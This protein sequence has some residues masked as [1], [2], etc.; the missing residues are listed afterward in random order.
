MSV[1][2]RK[3]P[4]SCQRQTQPCAGL[5]PAPASV[6]AADAWSR[7]ASV[8]SFRPPVGFWVPGVCRG[9]SRLNLSPFSSPAESSPWSLPQR[10]SPVPSSEAEQ[11]WGLGA[12]TLPFQEGEAFHCFWR[13]CSVKLPKRSVPSEAS[14]LVL[15]CTQKRNHVTQAPAFFSFTPTPCISFK[16]A[17]AKIEPASS[18]A[19]GLM[20]VIWEVGKKARCFGCI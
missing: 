20:S 3:T 1:K 14:R 6:P 2:L 10:S 18:P 15:S 16:R 9:T 11:S 8:S 17:A 13:P 19:K 12:G 7:V 5:P 4:F